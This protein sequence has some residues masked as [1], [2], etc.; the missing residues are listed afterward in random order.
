MLRE[1]F[2]DITGILQS[3]FKL[4]KAEVREEI[5]HI[6]TAAPMF[7]VG[8]VFALFALAFLLTGIML[9]IGSAV[10]Y[11]G[12]AFIIFGGTALV[13]GI[14]FLGGRLSLSKVKPPVK[15]IASMKENAEWLS[16]Q[17]KS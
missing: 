15:T 13:A 17:V 6:R 3:E 4:L 11:W 8:A 7:A 1:C 10:G 9:L 14:C 5:T 16:S 12:A 2:N